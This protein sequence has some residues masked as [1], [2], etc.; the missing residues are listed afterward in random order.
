M[1]SF[2]LII[3]LTRIRDMRTCGNRYKVSSCAD[4]ETAKEHQ[5]KKNCHHSDPRLMPSYS[6][7][8]SSLSDIVIEYDTEAGS[9][10]KQTK[11]NSFKRR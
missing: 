10:N 3:L 2:Q 5:E 9:T 11:K 1:T 4:N 6:K 8:L 7:K